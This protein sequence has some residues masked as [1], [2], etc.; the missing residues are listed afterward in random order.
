MK[1]IDWNTGKIATMIA[2]LYGLAIATMGVLIIQPYIGIHI[3]QPQAIMSLVPHFSLFVYSVC[4]A[5]SKGVYEKA[6]SGLLLPLC[7]LLIILGTSSSYSIMNNNMVYL[8]L[9]IERLHQEAAMYSMV[10]STSIYVIAGVGVYMWL[11][12][13]DKLLDD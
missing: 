11:N 10:Y 4:L 13:L 12:Q 7:T 5:I 3:T 9:T 6:I 8:A 1:H 2:S